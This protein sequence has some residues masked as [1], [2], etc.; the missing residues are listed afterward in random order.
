MFQHT[1][2]L[3]HSKTIFKQHTVNTIFSKTPTTILPEREHSECLELTD[4]RKS[5]QKSDSIADVAHFK[6]LT[7]NT[8]L[9]DLTHRSSS[10]SHWLHTV[11]RKIRTLVNVTTPSRL[12]VITKSEKD[13]VLASEFKWLSPQSRALETLIVVRVVILSA[14]CVNL[15]VHHCVHY[16][17]VLSWAQWI[18]STSRSPKWPLPLK[19]FDLLFYTCLISPI[20]AT[21]SENLILHTTKCRCHT[22][23]MEKLTSVVLLRS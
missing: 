15:E 21:W 1:D 6:Y 18:L 4:M 13:P 16:L 9:R 17:R 2:H 23:Y 11:T 10:C 14:F 20:R 3:L 12:H 8:C 5:F 22:C 7:W 19:D